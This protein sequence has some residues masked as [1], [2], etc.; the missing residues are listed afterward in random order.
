MNGYVI[1]FVNPLL[2]S[3]PLLISNVILTFLISYT[4]TIKLRNDHKAR[5]QLKKNKAADS[6]ETVSKQ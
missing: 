5:S 4:L 3:L 1:T 6:T 2:A